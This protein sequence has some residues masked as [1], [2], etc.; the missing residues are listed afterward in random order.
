ML[1]KDTAIEITIECLIWR[2][3]FLLLLIVFNIL[4]FYYFKFLLYTQLLFS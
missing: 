3:L 2:L 1:N 4:E